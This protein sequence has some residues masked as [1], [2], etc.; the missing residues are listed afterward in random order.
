[1]KI[2]WTQKS[3]P[4]LSELTKLEKKKAWKY[5]YRKCFGHWETYAGI[6][7]CGGCAG[8]GSFLWDLPGAAIGGG[9]GGF[10]YGQIA[11][12]VGRKHLADWRASNLEAQ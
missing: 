6:I 7:I 2:Y 4:E 8:L 1:M 11:I 9:I 12:A 10:I 5:A 3:V